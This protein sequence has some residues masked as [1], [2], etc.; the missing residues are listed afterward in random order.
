MRTVYGL[1]AILMVSLSGV[2]AAADAAPQEA[3]RIV[4]V[5]NNEVIT[6]NELRLR[7]AQIERQF[8][9]Q[10]MAAP[11]ADVMQRQMLERMI[12]DRAQLQFAQ[13]NG[14]RV[15][16]A[17]VDRALDRISESNQLP[18]PQFR[19]ALEKDGIAW[20][21]FRNEIRDEIT[22]VRLREREVD[23]RVVVSEAEVDNY[24]TSPARKAEAEELLVRHILIRIPE[25]SSP[26]RLAKLRARAEEAQSQLKLGMDFAQVAA[27]Y[28]DAPDALTGASLGWRAPERLPALFAEA[29][30]ALQPG[31]SSEILRS[32]AGFHIVKLDQR[33]GGTAAAK[34]VEQTSARHI[35]IKPTEI[36][37][38][39]E[40]RHKLEILK[41][42]LDHGGDFAEL[43]RLHSNDVSAPKGGDLGWLYPGDTVPEFE[44]AMNALKPGEISAPVHTPFGWHL[45]QGLERRVQDASA[46]RQRLL[47][48]QAIRERKADDAYQDWVRQLRDRTY[49]EV[50]LEEK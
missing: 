23:N 15:E 32:A 8:A 18:L 12:N 39:D 48:R 6:L 14:V 44:R 20:D 27:T 28:S 25:Q 29:A 22:L 9:Q 35:L 42:R 45:I 3:D 13:E 4:A 5:V 7:L 46:E 24:M 11:P 31:Q 49:V 30:G 40:A 21:K 19:A 2:T 38:D 41:D 36:L 33:R 1:L 26:E 16:D 10:K 37:S 17:Q 50:R 34:P 43:A 47:A